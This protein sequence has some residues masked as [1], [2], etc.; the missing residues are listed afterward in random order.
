MKAGPLYRGMERS[1]RYRTV[2]GGQRVGTVERVSLTRVASPPGVNASMG[3]KSFCSDL[4]RRVE[5]QL[6]RVSR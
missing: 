6:N 1:E 5:Y 2:I 4:D 3:A